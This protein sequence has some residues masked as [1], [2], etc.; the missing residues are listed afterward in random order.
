MRRVTF[1]FETR[2]LL[3]LKDAGAWAYAAH[4]STRVICLSLRDLRGHILRWEPLRLGEP[5]PDWLWE[6]ASDE[7]VVFDAHNAQFE[8]AIWHHQMVEKYGLPPL[9]PERWDDTMAVGFDRGMPGKL[10]DL[11]TVLGIEN[12]DAAGGK[13]I[14]KLSK[15]KKLTYKQS[16]SGRG[17]EWAGVYEFNEDPILLEQMA[18]YCDQDVVV[19]HQ[20]RERLGEL[21]E[22][23]RRTWVLD[24]R[25]N[26]R[27]LRIDLEAVAAA[28]RC[29]QRETARLRHRLVE[30]TDG[31]VTTEGQVARIVEFC[32]GRGIDLPGLAKADVAAAVEKYGDSGDK[33]AL[34]VLSI[35]QALGKS[36]TAKLERMAE[37]VSPDGR[38]RGLLQYQGA[39]STGRW[40][41]R[42]VQP[43]NVP[44][45]IGADPDELVAL[46]R[47]EALSELRERF[48]GVLNAVSG[49]LR[50]MF[51][52]DEGHE[53]VAG[54][55]A[56]IEARIVLALAGQWDRVE[57]L[58][59]GQ[60]A[61]LDMATSIFGYPCTDK[62]EHG[63]ERKVGKAAVLGLGFGCG[64][65]K[66]NSQFCPDR[67]L[68]FCTEVVRI[69]RKEWAPEVPKLWRRVEDAAVHAV[70]TGKPT[71][72]S[73]RLPEGQHTQVVRFLLES[74][75]LTCQLPSGRKLWYY[76]PELEADETPWGAPC[77]RLFFF[78][79]K[80]VGSGQKKWCRVSAYGG[81]LVENI[82]Q[83]VARDIM[84]DAL[85]RCESRNL[86]VIL[87]VHDELVTEV[88]KG[89]CTPAELERI[90]CAVE[91]WTQR[92][93]IPVAAEAWNGE[94]YR[95]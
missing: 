6:M 12:K 26:Q 16:A 89:V 93:Q 17:E 29:V 71:T 62:H 58:R 66:F 64:D 85:F 25:I 95:K 69:Y 72:V 76:G 60:D 18:D 35:R 13:L 84:R 75:W 38:A 20:A 31:V 9:P 94:R 56:A 43:Q 37:V 30:L 10:D 73:V 52:A 82:V 2:S 4:H 61:Y 3:K 44:G 21:D 11:A 59:M 34:E 81:L 87:T 1:D 22:D 33:A 91:P 28:K 39:A 41:G 92:L 67:E 24:Q 63:A 74:E 8:Q 83:A 86:P 51:I 45:G 15:P 54:D 7:A 42:L 79:E 57:L 50:H 53:L 78:A 55:Y 32:R 5:V 88:R 65:S 27:G 49:A 80:V 48:G 70:R 40:A 77:F 14:D 19:E 46:I 68:S 23:E 47:A 36:S 90:M